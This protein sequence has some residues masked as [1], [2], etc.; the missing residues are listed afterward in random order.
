MGT[1][2][3]AK[4]QNYAF[5]PVRVTWLKR[6]VLLFANSIGVNA[7]DLHLLYELHPGFA[8]F[9]TYPLCLSFKE[10]DQEVNDF[11]A[12]SQTNAMRNAIP[13]SP[14]IDYRRMVDGERYFEMLKPTPTSSQ[15]RNFELRGKSIGIWDKVVPFSMALM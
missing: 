3:L 7:K 4:A 1:T 14:Q 15:G 12:K 2:D 5:P 9:P 6:D 10:T 13:G 8:S 11:L